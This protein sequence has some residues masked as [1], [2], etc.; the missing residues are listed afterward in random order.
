M[1]LCKNEAGV[2]DMC[3][4][5]TH[6]QDAPKSILHFTQGT[7][8]ITGNKMPTYFENIQMQVDT[9]YLF[10]QR[11]HILDVIFRN[12]KG[13]SCSGFDYVI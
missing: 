8:G 1:I 3:L 9:D 6:T 11:V 2:P 4:L 7:V 12:I 13:C 10:M 5:A